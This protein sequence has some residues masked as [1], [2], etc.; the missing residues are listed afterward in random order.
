[1]NSY[2]NILYHHI[3]RC[4][5]EINV[6]LVTYHRDIYRIALRVPGGMKE[7]II[8]IEYD[9]NRSNNSFKFIKAD[10]EFSEHDSG[11]INP[12]TFFKMYF[13]FLDEDMIKIFKNAISGD[14]KK[15]EIT[16]NNSALYFMN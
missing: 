10:G 2:S 7:T 8:G 3:N 4:H 1:M 14:K 16:I 11:A 9:F 6:S 15:K 12:Q 5:M 13:H